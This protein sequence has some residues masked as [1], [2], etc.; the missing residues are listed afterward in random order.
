MPRRG[1]CTRRHADPAAR[2]PAPQTPRAWAIR[3]VSAASREPHRSE[4]ATPRRSAEMGESSSDSSRILILRPLRSPR[5]SAAQQIH[6]RMARGVRRSQR[7]R[8]PASRRG[9]ARRAAGTTRSKPALVGPRSPRRP[10]RRPDAARCRAG[11]AHP[12]GRLLPQGRAVRGAPSDPRLGEHPT[13]ARGLWR[14]RVPDSRAPQCPRLPRPRGGA[15][16]A[17][18]AARPPARRLLRVRH[19]RA[20]GRDSERTAPPARPLAR[21]PEQRRQRVRHR[22]GAA[23]PRGGR[24]R[25]RARPRAPGLL[26]ERHRQQRGTRTA[27]L[28]PGRWRGRPALTDLATRRRERRPSQAGLASAQLRVSLHQ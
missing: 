26:L 21:G 18:I 16:A 15:Q 25:P 8:R 28:R 22:P 9:R 10:L 19:R 12:V 23:A 5:G 1:G 20:G 2:E 7:A 27:P 24:P 4:D 14:A 11:A 17:G 13:R 3:G 6:P